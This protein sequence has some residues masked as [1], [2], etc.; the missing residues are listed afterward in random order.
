MVWVFEKVLIKL[1][2]AECV[3]SNRRVPSA[4]TQRLEWVADTEVEPPVVEF[5]KSGFKNACF[6]VAGVVHFGS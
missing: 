4:W 6:V 3:F 1:N 5:E 2:S